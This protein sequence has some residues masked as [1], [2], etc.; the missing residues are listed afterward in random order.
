MMLNA[1]VYIAYLL[2]F[3]FTTVCLAA[4][5]YYLAE[6]VE[7]YAFFTKKVLRISIW[8]VVVIHILL[9]ATED[10]G[11]LE[12]GIGLLAHAVY[13]SLLARFPLVNLSS[14]RFLLSVACVILNHFMWF[15]FFRRHYFP[16]SQIASIFFICVWLLPFSFFVSLS[17]NE[18]T[19]PYGNPN[20]ATASG[21]Y[22]TSSRGRSVNVLRSLF[23]L[24]RRKTES[25]LPSLQRDPSS[26]SHTQKYN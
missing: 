20:I 9:W 14:P 26:I 21:D 17:A 15:L 19:L 8:V 11:T 10:V 13:Y 6:L 4:G 12:V 18:N 2:L 23:G 1:L 5:L 7:E 16:F 24:L 25:V 3:L 22:L